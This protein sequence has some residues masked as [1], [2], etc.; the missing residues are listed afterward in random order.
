MSDHNRYLI[1]KG[2]CGL[3]NRLMTLVNALK[4]SEKTGRIISVDWC[5]G[6]FASKGTNA[7][8]EYFEIK[9]FAWQEEVNTHKDSAS[10]FYPDVLKNLPDDFGLDEYF[11]TASANKKGSRILEKLIHFGSGV[12]HALLSED[13]F[14]FYFVLWARWELSSCHMNMRSHKYGGN[15]FCLGGDLPLARKEEVIVFGDFCPTYDKCYLRKHLALKQNIREEIENF[16]NSNTMGKGMLGL[17]IRCTDKSF[18]QDIDKTFQMVEKFMQEHDLNK[19]FLATDQIRVI[20]KA[21]QSFGGSLLLYDKY[22][23]ALESGGIHGI[24]T[25]ASEQED[26]GIK[27]RMYHDAIMEMYL[28]AET[29]YLLYQGNSTFSSISRDI[30]KYNNC[31]DWQKII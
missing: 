19:L 6:M 21:K 13:Y 12:A 2:T 20:E 28:L 23:P 18:E 27:T 11:H 26:E 29:E 31:Y 1:V 14:K 15:R 24:H 25:W 5:D 17:H 4:Y 8:T 7:F 22:L 10:S 30:S 9:N 16:S 3:G